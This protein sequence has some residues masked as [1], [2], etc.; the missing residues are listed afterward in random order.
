MRGRVL[1]F[2]IVSLM[3]TGVAEAAECRRVADAPFIKIDPKALRP[4]QEV[5][6]DRAYIF[7]LGQSVAQ[8]E[9]S[10]CWAGTSDNF[11]GQLISAGVLQWNYG[12]NSV[13]PLLKNFKT[14]R[15]ALFPRF[16]QEN[17]PQFGDLV[18]S[19]RCLSDRPKPVKG[20]AQ[21]H[22]CQ[23]DFL[24]PADNDGK[25]LKP[26]LKAEFTKLFE[27]DGMIQIQMD[28]VM[29][30][31][32]KT[33]DF[34]ERMFG[35]DAVSPK[36][37]HWMFDI[38]VQQGEFPSLEAFKKNFARAWA[39]ARTQDNAHQKMTAKGILLWYA[40]TRGVS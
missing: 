20:E 11:D 13:Q 2:V 37:F 31:M 22:P 40:G 38:I 19:P 18:F 27:S 10:G 28:F 39:Y 7:K 36:N 14:G 6:L 15:G 4:F 33:L 25:R 32:S 9:T 17:M 12:Q 35:K 29:Q 34:A 24:D 16:I 8:V 26:E 1:L 23:N 3:S 21:P 5:K 30:Q